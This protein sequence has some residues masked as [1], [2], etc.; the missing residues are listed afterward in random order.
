M[1]ALIFDIETLAHPS[2]ADHVP[3]PDVSTIQAPGTWKDP[4]KIAAEI[5]RKT[6]EALDAHTQQVA[7]CALDWNLSTICAIGVHIEDTGMT[8]TWIIHDEAEERRALAAFWILARRRTLVGFCARTFDVPTL[9]QRSRLLQV[10][11]PSISLARFGKGDV[12]DLRDLL[13]FD[14]ARYEA[15]MPRSL[16]AFARRFGVPVP[17]VTDGRDVAAMAAAGDFD[18]I[19]AHCAADVQLTSALAVR[20]GVVRAPAEVA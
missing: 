1:A 19:K 17:D 4:V 20:L 15:I 7:R 3:P 6:A 5:E 11:Y 14:D 16:K 8:D 10:P 13:T 18:G 9:I 12:V 2:A